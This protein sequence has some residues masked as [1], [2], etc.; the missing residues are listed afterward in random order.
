MPA[1]GSV[2]R[3]R[4]NIRIIRSRKRREVSNSVS[5]TTPLKNGRSTRSTVSSLSPASRQACSAET[6]RR[7]RMLLTGSAAAV[8]E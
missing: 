7:P 5:S 3:P 2:E 4:T 1:A 6:S 8:A